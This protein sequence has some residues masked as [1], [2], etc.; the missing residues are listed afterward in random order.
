MNPVTMKITTPP[1]CPE[2]GGKVGTHE[3]GCKAKPIKRYELT[4]F[5][6][7]YGSTSS[8]DE[9]ADGDFVKFED[10]EKADLAAYS[11]GL[12]DGAVSG[13]WQAHLYCLQNNEPELAS[14]F[15]E[16]SHK[17]AERKE[18]L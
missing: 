7:N 18:N 17:V 2:C 9:C 13:L 1:P 12:T 3:E 6:R 14:K 4:E 8:M 15:R 10:H 16:M 5:V 11:R